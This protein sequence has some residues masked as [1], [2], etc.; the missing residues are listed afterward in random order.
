MKISDNAILE[1]LFIKD[2]SKHLVNKELTGAAFTELNRQLEC[3]RKTL[4]DCYFV[5]ND[6]DEKTGKHCLVFRTGMIAYFIWE[7][8]L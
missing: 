5:R 6:F 8:D 1:G 3:N 2:I 4:D 7:E